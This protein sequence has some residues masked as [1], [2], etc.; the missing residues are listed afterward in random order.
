MGRSSERTGR[1]DLASSVLYA[2]LDWI[3]AHRESVARMV[4]ATSR[5]SEWARNH[6]ASE[7]RELLPASIRTDDAAVDTDAIGSMVAMMSPD[8]KFRPEH[9]DAAREILTVS[10][11]SLR[12]RTADVSHSYTNEFLKLEV[13]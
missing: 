4:R 1:E 11:P 8:G 13:R 12:I 10:D 9:L 5:A 7:I 6:S 3:S 2:K